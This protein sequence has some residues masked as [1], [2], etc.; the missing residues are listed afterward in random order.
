[1][2][3][4]NALNSDDYQTGLASALDQALS[5]TGSAPHIG[6]LDELFRRCTGGFDPIK[7]F[8]G[9]LTQL[10]AS[11]ACPQPLI[12]RID[13]FAYA[14]LKG[15]KNFDLFLPPADTLN[16]SFHEA[17]SNWDTEIHALE[18]FER[19]G[20]ALP[21]SASVSAEA[22]LALRSIVTRT[23]ARD[24]RRVLA[25]LL[26]SGPSSLQEVSADLR[27]NYT[28]GERTLA[29]FEPAPLQAIERRGDRFA[30]RSPVL[31]LVL[32]CLRETM[33]IDLLSALRP[34]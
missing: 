29:V 11:G 5:Q 22:Y 21:M 15:A 13:G 14:F 24:E 34:D 26:V 4:E 27:L 17:L 33:G 19:W 1:L 7:Q 25:T 16:A 8:T 2:L 32:F 28:L 12:C 31:P 30:I 20:K 10:S 6:G 23:S 18:R 3:H 9:A